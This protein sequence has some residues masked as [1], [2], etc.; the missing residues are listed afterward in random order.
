MGRGRGRRGMKRVCRRVMGRERGL[1]G[2]GR[3][4]EKAV[5]GGGRERGRGQE[6]GERE[7][8]GGGWGEKRRR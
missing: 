6:D 8:I 5:G 1:E 3:E 4:R 2:I 7:G